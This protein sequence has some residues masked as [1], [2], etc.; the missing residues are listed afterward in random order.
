M[1]IYSN[2]ASS[3]LDRLVAAELPKQRGLAAWAALLQAH[4]T[5]MRRLESCSEERTSP[6]LRSTT[7]V[8]RLALGSFQFYRPLNS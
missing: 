2:D 6:G 3:L 4:A 8:S 1:Q 5:L 7:Y